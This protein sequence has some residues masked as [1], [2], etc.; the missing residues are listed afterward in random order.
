[1]KS[2]YY[3]NFNG[4]EYKVISRDRNG[5]TFLLSDSA[6]VGFDK[7]DE[8]IYEKEINKADLTNFYS[9]EPRAKYEGYTFPVRTKIIKGNV[10]I[11]TDNAE[12]AK[13]LNFER[14]DKYFYEKWIS[15]ED[16]QII[17]ERKDFTIKSE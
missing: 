3:T 9:I 17:E 4:K 14:T 1:M 13:K 5:K 10:C 2:G 12:L 15:K 7:Y 6:E 16:I 11:G 8:G